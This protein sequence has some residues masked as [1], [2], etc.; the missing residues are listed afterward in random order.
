M[1][2]INRFVV[3]TDDK[4]IIDSCNCVHNT[5][6]YHEQNHFR[7]KDFDDN[8]YLLVNGARCHDYYVLIIWSYERN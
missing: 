1:R 8:T 4:R 5:D 7:K 3:N 6:R 2:I